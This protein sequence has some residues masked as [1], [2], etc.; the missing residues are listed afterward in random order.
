VYYVVN[1]AQ[2]GQQFAAA[3][4]RAPA[5][6][7]L[8][9]KN[10]LQDP[11]ACHVLENVTHLFEGG[12]L[13]LSEMNEDVL[14][15]FCYH[16]FGTRIVQKALEKGVRE[17]QS[18]IAM[19]VQ[20]RG[21]HYNPQNMTPAKKAYFEDAN[22]NH[23][24]AALM[25]YCHQSTLVP[26]LDQLW[27]SRLGQQ[28]RHNFACRYLQRALENTS[29]EVR[30]NMAWAILTDSHPS[31]SETVT[32]KS[33][34]EQQ[35]YLDPLILTLCR[36]QYGCYVA[37]SCYTNLRALAGEEMTER[38]QYLISAMEYTAVH[39]WEEFATQR[40]CSRVLERM[41]QLG[42]RAEGIHPAFPC[43]FDK[44]GRGHV[45]AQHVLL[46]ALFERL[47]VAERTEARYDA[48]VATVFCKLLG[49]PDRSLVQAVMRCLQIMHA[50]DAREKECNAWRQAAKEALSF[51]RTLVE[52]RVSGGR[53][54]YEK[55]EH[56]RRY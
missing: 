53:D 38:A 2:Y 46:S 54:R 45:S 56:S 13:R 6:S 52:P 1:K 3:G 48:R 50:R 20:R 27:R 18:K 55:G 43:H 35:G 4:L 17:E 22:A 39:H 37:Q 47:D 12:A 36:D 34:P 40:H 21:L 28:A 5:L 51:V 44:D 10:L 25:Q 49:Q 26:L 11:R 8:E 41:L 7:P 9:W 15:D 16:Q 42:P 14:N 24:V 29:G 23:V 33:F 30:I 32:T 31:D 19:V